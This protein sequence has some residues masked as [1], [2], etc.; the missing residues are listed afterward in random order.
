VV[1]EAAGKARYVRLLLPD[2]LPERRGGLW[3]WEVLP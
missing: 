1:V 3:E 2:E